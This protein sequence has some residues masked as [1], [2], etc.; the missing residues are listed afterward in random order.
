MLCDTLRPI[1]TK[2]EVLGLNVRP[3]SYHLDELKFSVDDLKSKPDFLMATKTCKTDN[4]VTTFSDIK[5]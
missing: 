3:P 2:T 4:D 5:N 1:H